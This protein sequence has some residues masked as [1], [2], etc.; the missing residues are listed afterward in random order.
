[1]EALPGD[2][3]GELEVVEGV[4]DGVKI[5]ELNGLA[6]A[7]SPQDAPEE[8]LKIATKLYKASR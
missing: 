6:S 8:M 1:M 2:P 3:P 4:P 5:A 7:F